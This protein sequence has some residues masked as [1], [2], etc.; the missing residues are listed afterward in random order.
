MPLTRVQTTAVTLVA[1]A[2]LSAACAPTLPTRPPASSAGDPVAGL[3]ALDDFGC[4][5]CHV[6]PGTSGAK[7][8]VGP[9]LVAWAQRSYIAGTL[10]NSQPNL[11]RWISDPQSVRPGTAMP[12]LGVGPVDARDI[13]AYLFSIDP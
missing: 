2:V 1:T 3:Q 12:D 13:A 4:A 11:E 5:S 9:P 8:Y 10:A 6:I 7:A